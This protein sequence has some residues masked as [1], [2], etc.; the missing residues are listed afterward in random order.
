[1]SRLRFLGAICLLVVS[2]PIVRGAELDAGQSPPNPGTK[3]RN[4]LLVTTDGLRWQEVFGGA[5]PALVTPDN[6]AKSQ[7]DAVKKEFLIGTPGERRAALMP[8]MWSVIARQ[9]QLFG[10]ADAGSEARVTNGKNFSYPGY[11][12][13]FT[14]RAD[15]AIDSNDK[16]PN[17]NVSVLEWLN[18][19]D[20][21]R[22]RVAAYG[23]WDVFPFILNQE[24]SGIKV[25]GGWRP[26]S[27]EGLSDR[28]Q[29]INTLMRETPPMWEGCCF[30]SF[31]CS[32]AA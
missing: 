6:V 30:D 29:L 19:K 26:L 27:G 13:I 3:T 20:A 2:C 16:I 1:M 28:E 9:G 15:P 32:S 5:D 8:F 31:K 11:N 10:N 12:E 21:F 7:L 25:V 4:I 22:G 17:K 23:S 18:Q 24:R 14:G